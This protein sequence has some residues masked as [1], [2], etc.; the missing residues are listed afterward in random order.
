MIEK[1]DAAVFRCSLFGR[2]SD[3]WLEVPAWMFDRALSTNWHITA[4]PHVG[5]A[6]LVVLAT[7]LRDI[8][9]PSQLQ[10][11]GA[12]LGSHDTNRGDAHA[13]QGKHP[14]STAGQAA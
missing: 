4:A 13:A 6:A 2:A 8:D 12:A 11:M 14:V 1:G 5:I 10:G 3:R 9:N 7:L